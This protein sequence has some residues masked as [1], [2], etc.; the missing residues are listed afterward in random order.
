MCVCVYVCV[1]L[2]WEWGAWLSKVYKNVCVCVCV[3][4]C[5]FVVGVGSVAL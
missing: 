4:V 3:C 1:Y 2:L 5:V